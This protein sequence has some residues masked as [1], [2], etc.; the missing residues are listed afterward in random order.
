M[1]AGTRFEKVVEPSFREKGLNSQV[2]INDVKRGEGFHRIV[3]HFG[4]DIAT[5]SQKHTVALGNPGQIMGY[6]KEFDDKYPAG[7]TVKDV[8]TSQNRDIVGQQLDGTRIL[9]IQPQKGITAEQAAF[10]AKRDI[11]IADP[12]GR[13]YNEVEM[14]APMRP[15]ARD[16]IDIRALGLSATSRRVGSGL[17]AVGAPAIGESIGH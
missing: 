15:E 5:V 6:I 9:L 3:D 17:L 10:A 12:M 7:A 14:G 1:H 16:A 8:P 2:Y 13:V 4:Q 11:Y